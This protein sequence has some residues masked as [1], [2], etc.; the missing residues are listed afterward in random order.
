MKRRLRPGTR[1]FQQGS[2][3]VEAAVCILFI[4]V[5]LLSSIFVYGRFFW[6]Y[7]AV[8]KSVHDAALYMATAPLSEIKSNAASNFANEI[9]ARETADFSPDTTVETSSNCG[10]KASPTSTKY[11][12]ITCSTTT[13]PDAVQSVVIL[14]VPMPF[15]FETDSIKLF[16]FAVMH[17]AGK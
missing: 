13:T 1:K 16:P 5:P 4:L 9:V 12:F 6:Y 8:Q 15:F 11:L 3:S 2:V 17:Y 7:T 14:T 10:Y